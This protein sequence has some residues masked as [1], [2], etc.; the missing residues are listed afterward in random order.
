MGST[1][2]TASFIGVAGSDLG[3]EWGYRSQEAQRNLL[4]VLLVFCNGT[5]PSSGRILRFAVWSPTSLWVDG[6]DPNQTM[7][8]NPYQVEHTPLAP[9]PGSR[10]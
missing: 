6:T 3:F 10:P 5:G 7:Q 2:F 8:E 4:H 1:G 9:L